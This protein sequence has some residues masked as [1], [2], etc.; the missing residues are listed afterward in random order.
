MS[1][2]K[3]FNSLN[4]YLD[5]LLAILD[6]DVNVKEDPKKVDELK[7]QNVELMLEVDLLKK[8]KNVAKIAQEKEEMRK[9]FERKIR[10]MKDELEGKDNAL[11]IIR[12]KEYDYFVKLDKSKQAIKSLTNKPTMLNHTC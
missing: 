8:E 9:F 1:Q 12:V 4:D 6:E 5:E 3:L 2:G 7:S 10:V 11:K